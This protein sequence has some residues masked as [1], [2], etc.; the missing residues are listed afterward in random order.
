LLRETIKADLANSSKT[1]AQ[2]K[3]DLTTILAAN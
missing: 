2:M 3:Q 1:E